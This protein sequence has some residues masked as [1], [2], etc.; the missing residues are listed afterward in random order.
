MKSWKAGERAIAKI[1]GCERIPITGR[2]TSRGK[3]A[4]LVSKWLAV[5]V[6]TRKRLPLF[7]AQVMA[8]AEAGALFAQKK[9][10]RRR[11][12]IGVLHEDGD[13]YG[14]SVV[15]LRLKDFVEHFGGAEEEAA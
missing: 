12:P 4:D 9:D 5:E 8:Q 2:H 13:R 7:L 11:L 10:G 15:C 1:L 6:K 3:P 14:E